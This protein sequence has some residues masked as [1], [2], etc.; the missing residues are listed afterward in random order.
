MDGIRSV[1]E[2]ISSQVLISRLADWGV[3]TVFGIP[4]DGI[5]G[6]MEGLR[7]SADRVRFTFSARNAILLPDRCGVLACL[8]CLSRRRR[9]SPA[10]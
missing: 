6:I 2:T 8:A 3:D 4:G 9:D 7:R 10:D 5:D 1:M